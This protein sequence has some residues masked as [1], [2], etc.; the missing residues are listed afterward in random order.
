MIRALIKNGRIEP[1]EPLPPDW[2][3]GQALLIDRAPSDDP[4]DIDRWARQLEEAAAAL[5]A[6]DVVAFRRALDEVERESKESVRRDWG[7][8]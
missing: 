3:D 7:L 6:D 4:E 1:T 5:P 8:S 2:A